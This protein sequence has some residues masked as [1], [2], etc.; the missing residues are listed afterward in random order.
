MVE[1]S[2]Y[3]INPKTTN[4]I[5]IGDSDLVSGYCKQYELQSA[6]DPSEGW[7]WRTTD[8]NRKVST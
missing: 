7:L 1:I 2:D 5:D 6:A 3:D 8:G 4:A